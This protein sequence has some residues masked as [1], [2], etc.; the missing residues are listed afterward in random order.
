MKYYPTPSQT[1]GPFFHL[2][3]F[4]RRSFGSLAGA[5]AKGQRVRLICSL[6]DGDGDPVPDAMLEVWQANAE[7]RYRHPSDLQERLIDPALNGFGRFATAPD[8]SCAFE[9]V[10]PGKVPGGNNSMQA[11][12]LNVSVFARGL[13]KRVTTRLY[14][15]GDPA[16]AEDPILALVPEER[17]DTLL[18]QPIPEKP[19]RWGFNIHLSGANETVFFDI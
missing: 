12:H 2:G 6:F 19:G 18:A 15:A 3:F 7:G 13:L 9:T 5:G 14:F 11:P 4:G 1:V 8:G 17:R 10:R 16:N